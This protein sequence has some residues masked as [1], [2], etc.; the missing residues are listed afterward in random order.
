MCPRSQ[1]RP[2]GL[3]LWDLHCAGPQ[4]LWRF[5]QHLSAKCSGRPKKFLLSEREPLADA[6]LYYSKSAPGYC[7]TFIK[8][9]EEG[10]R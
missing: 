6:V 10:L 3:Y 2:R 7:I 1:R 9:L 8:R 5:L 4:P